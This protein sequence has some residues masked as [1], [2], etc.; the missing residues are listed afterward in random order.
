MSEQIS[1]VV[2]MSTPSMGGTLTVAINHGT[3]ESADALS[4][5]RQAARRVNA[6]ANRLTR[7]TSTSDLTA[8]NSSADTCVVVRPTLGAVLEWAATATDRTDG[9][10]DATML[11]ARLAAEAGSAR[12][13]HELNRSDRVRWTIRPA[14]RGAQVERPSTTRFDLDGLAKGWLADRATDLLSRWPGAAVA[15]DGDVAI[16]AGPGVE[17]SIGVEDPRPE[18]DHKPLLATLRVRGGSSWS[19]RFGVATSGTS[20]HRWDL[21]G[22]RTSHHLIDPRTGRPAETDVVQATVIA[23]TAR[24][25]EVIAKTAVILGSVEAL[26]FLDRSAALAAVVLLESGDI[27]CLPGIESWLA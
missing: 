17:W 26:K 11:D 6:W 14:A 24:E 8:L 4:S 20:V 9:V 16:S 25:A 19:T 12:T 3:A 22:G 15:A 7:F 2:T 23:P 18:S 1:Q 21:P 10:V 5:A 13:P 27:C